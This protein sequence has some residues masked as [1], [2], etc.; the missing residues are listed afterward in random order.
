MTEKERLNRVLKDG[1]RRVVRL[2]A[3][4]AGSAVKKYLSQDGRYA[5]GVD[6]GIQRPFGL[7]R[8]FGY[9]GG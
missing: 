3:F 4:S 1:I 5:L 6:D 8:S 9:D 7:F 2:S